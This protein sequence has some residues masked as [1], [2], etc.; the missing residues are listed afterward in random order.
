VGLNFWVNLLE[1]EKKELTFWLKNLGSLGVRSLLPCNLK[2]VR[3]SADARDAGRG[4]VL[5]SVVV[6]RDFGAQKGAVAS[7]RLTRDERV[8]S[9]TSREMRGILLAVKAFEG[10][11]GGRGPS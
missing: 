8:E 7:R 10:V 1:G 3:L 9:S 2:K 5:R 4:A 6:D 11:L